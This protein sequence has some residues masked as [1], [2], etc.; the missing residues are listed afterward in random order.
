MSTVF[1]CT[2]PYSCSCY[3]SSLHLL[4]SAWNLEWYWPSRSEQR[5]EYLASAALAPVQQLV[6]ATVVFYWK[7]TKF[8]MKLI[9]TALENVSRVSTTYINEILE[10][11]CICIW[12][13]IAHADLISHIHHLCG[14]RIACSL[15]GQILQ[16][17]Y[18]IHCFRLLVFILLTWK[19]RS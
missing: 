3:W 6:V 12:I 19:F 4:H 17:I 7:I 15:V 14:H 1:W 9:L 11:I 16:R 13:H 5:L 18:R 10:Y 2:N 8:T